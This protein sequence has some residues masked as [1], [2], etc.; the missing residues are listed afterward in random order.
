MVLSR[1]VRAI[2][3]PG[4]IVRIIWLAL[5]DPKDVLRRLWLRFPFGPPKPTV[6]TMRQSLPKKLAMTAYR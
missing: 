5:L 2:K 4:L 3:N 6:S 1:L